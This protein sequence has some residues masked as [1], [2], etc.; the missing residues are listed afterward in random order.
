M[1]TDGF[2]VSGGLAANVELGGLRGLGLEFIKIHMLSDRILY[3]SYLIMGTV[4]Q[5]LYHQPYP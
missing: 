1:L 5:D 2:G 4:V 3:Q